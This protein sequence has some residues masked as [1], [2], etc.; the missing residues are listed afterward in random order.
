MFIGYRDSI[1]LPF[2]SGTYDGER[3]G[4]T[5]IILA[6]LEKMYLNSKTIIE[7]VY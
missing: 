3:D 2:L 5:A 7:K 4:R 6:I 1:G